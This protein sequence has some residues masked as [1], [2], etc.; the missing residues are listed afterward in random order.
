MRLAGFSAEFFARCALQGVVNL[1]LRGGVLHAARNAVSGFVVF[2][3]LRGVPLL[4][5][6][7]SLGFRVH[8]IAREGLTRTWHERDTMITC[9]GSHFDYMSCHIA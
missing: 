5:G 9:E 4:T 8:A 1:G 3:G 2:V 7:I 6:V